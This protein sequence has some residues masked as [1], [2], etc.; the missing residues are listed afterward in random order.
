M[1]GTPPTTSPYFSFCPRCG[2]PL[3]RAEVAGRER[4]RC[5]APGCGFV[6]YLNP[7]T[8]V[9]AVIRDG[10]GRVLLVRKRATGAWSFPSGYVEWDEDVR[11]AVAR[12]VREE[13]GLDANAGDVLAVHSNFHE[14]GR[15]TIGIW[16]AAALREGAFQLDDAEIDAAEY[17]PLDAVPPLAYPTDERVIEQVRAAGPPDRSSQ[18]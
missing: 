7:A 3:E 11:G 2:A 9:A 1:A 10:E 12:E 13:L 8:G 16:Y 6:Q 5:A 14:D 17:F 15:H 4:P 18:A